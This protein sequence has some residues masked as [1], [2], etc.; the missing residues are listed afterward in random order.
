MSDFDDAELV[1][2][3]AEASGSEN[4]VEVAC[5]QGGRVLVRD[6]KDPSGPRLVFTSEEWRCFLVGV[7]G[8]EFALDRVLE[9]RPRP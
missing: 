9:G 7:R 6:S 5:G 1:W 3:K 8:G 4:C 2:R